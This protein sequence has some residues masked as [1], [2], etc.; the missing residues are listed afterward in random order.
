MSK[1]ASP[2][3]PHKASASIIGANEVGLDTGFQALSHWAAA[4]LTRRPEI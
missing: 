3:I 2:V 1:L 4:A